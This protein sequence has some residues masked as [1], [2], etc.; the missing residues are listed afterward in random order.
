MAGFWGKVRVSAPPFSKLNFYI[1]DKALF[2]LKRD[3][4]NLVIY[5]VL[6]VYNQVKGCVD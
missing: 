6:R 5:P 2:W 4:S 1:T 3:I